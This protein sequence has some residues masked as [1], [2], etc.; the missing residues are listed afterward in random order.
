MSDGTKKWR[1]AD[2]RDPLAMSN[3]TVYVIA[4][5]DLRIPGAS[6]MNDTKLREAVI[7]HARNDG[8]L[9]E[10]GDRTS[11]AAPPTEERK[12]ESVGVAMSYPP[13]SERFPQLVD[14]TVAEALAAFRDPWNMPEDGKIRAML[15]GERLDE[16]QF[17]STVLKS[18]DRLEIGRPAGEKQ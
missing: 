4:R 8:R 15:N 3:D 7:A 2:L 13:Y 5:D 16:K 10:D 9:I 6:T 12:P 17:A 14:K 11:A 1:L 18:G